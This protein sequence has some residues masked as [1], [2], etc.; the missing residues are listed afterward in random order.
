MAKAVLVVAVRVPELK[1]TVS[2]AVGTCCGSQLV[3]LFQAVEDE[4]FHVRIAE[5]ALKPLNPG[6]TSVMINVCR[7]RFMVLNPL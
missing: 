2:L 3:A 7:M 1:I 5:R 4:P 6:S